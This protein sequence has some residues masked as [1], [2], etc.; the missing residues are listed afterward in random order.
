MLVRIF[1]RNTITRLPSPRELDDKYAYGQ[2]AIP[3]LN[4]SL[5]NTSLH[6]VC[7]IAI[8][9]A[10][11]GDRRKSFDPKALVA[12]FLQALGIVIFSQL[13]RLSFVFRYGTWYANNV[14]DIS[15]RHV[16]GRLS[17]V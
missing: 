3:R 14:L 2:E 12:D 8:G 1:E 16:G 4:A 5:R 11:R 9:K 13:I 6:V 7:E 15:S 10:Q 17:K